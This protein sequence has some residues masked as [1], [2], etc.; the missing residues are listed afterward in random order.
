[1]GRL[2]NRE[3]EQRPRVAQLGGNSHRRAP[4]NEKR[5]LAPC[6]G[7]AFR[8]RLS[9][10]PRPGAPPQGG[11]ESTA[12]FTGEGAGRTFAA[13]G[14]TKA[15]PEA[16]SIANNEPAGG[17]S[18]AVDAGVGASARLSCSCSN[19]RRFLFFSDLLSSR[20]PRESPRRSADC[21]SAA[22]GAAT[23]RA[24][25]T[26]ASAASLVLLVADATG[27][28]CAEP[29]LLTSSAAAPAPPPSEAPK[30]DGC[31]AAFSTEKIDRGACAPVGGGSGNGRNATAIGRAGLSA[32]PE[33]APAPDDCTLKL[34]ER[35]RGMDP[36]RP[37]KTPEGRICVARNAK[38]RTHSCL[39][40]AF[41][42]P[43]A[44]NKRFPTAKAI[45]VDRRLSS[46]SRRFASATWCCKWTSSR[47]AMPPA[48]DNNIKIEIDAG[49]VALRQQPP[50]HERRLGSSA[51]Y[52]DPS[53]EATASGE[54]VIRRPGLQGK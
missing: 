22:S 3:S 10:A 50:G 8:A 54:S 32:C 19:W 7:R 31:G 42:F 45:S 23:S 30:S 51:G 11:T 34:F 49:M 6:S 38:Q 40:A 33:A 37:H 48:K 29:S 27:R 5:L 44:R 43:V 16:A 4:E 41:V 39:S 24:G 52:G 28:A 47:V 15:S 13:A 25:S 2:P 14:R 9:A 20:S 12:F 53:D 17:C 26:E 18:G 21:D 36:H 1:M 46:R 35:R